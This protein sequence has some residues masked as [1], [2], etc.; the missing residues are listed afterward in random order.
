MGG[1]RWVVVMFRGVE[2]VWSRNSAGP[3]RQCLSLRMS[4]EMAC[5]Y[6]YPSVSAIVTIPWSMDL[7]EVDSPR[8]E[9]DDGI[10]CRCK[11]LALIGLPQGAV[12]LTFA[13]CRFPYRG[14]QNVRPAA[15]SPLNPLE[16]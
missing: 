3:S 4:I 8:R 7:L 11:E 16:H 5:P 15:V 10:H 14:R 2:G 13:G 6:N 9:I 12:T 1:E